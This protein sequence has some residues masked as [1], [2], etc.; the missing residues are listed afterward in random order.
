MTG[1][2][3]R[4]VTPASGVV[5]A[6]SASCAWSRG[7]AET[8]KRSWMPGNSGAVDMARAGATRGV[9]EARERGERGEKRERERREGDRHTDRDTE[10]Q[11]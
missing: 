7:A 11:R 8:G 4:M 2:L 3:C 10:I 1:T 5:A 6:K 9:R